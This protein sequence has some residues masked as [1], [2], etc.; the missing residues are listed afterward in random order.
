M[1]GMI[2]SV[3]N[4]LLASG[5][6]LLFAIQDGQNPK[7]SL[8]GIEAATAPKTAKPLAFQAV[9][10]APSAAPTPE[11]VLT[12]VLLD[13]QSA[14]VQISVGL[15]IEGS[16]S[17][18]PTLHLSQA[19]DQ[20]ELTQNDIAAPISAFGFAANSRVQSATLDDAKANFRTDSHFALDR[21][22]AETESIIKAVIEEIR[23]LDGAKVVAAIDKLGENVQFVADAG[24]WVRKGIETLKSALDALV[25]LLGPK[26]LAAIKD[27][28]SELW[29]KFEKGEYTRDILTRIYGVQTTEDRIEATLAR[30]NLSPESLDHAGNALRPLT[31][32]FAANIKLIRGILAAVALI[33]GALAF[34]HVAL[35][36]LP[37]AAAG[38]Y[39]TLI[40]AAVIVGMSYSGAGRILPGIPDVREIAEHIQA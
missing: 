2:S 39:A 12:R 17:P 10:N 35:P 25:Q 14:N 3:S 38:A 5:R 30:P 33:V 20:I 27:K 23:K 36:W 29:S 9:G 24:H 28:V 32:S 31:E 18:D 13:L 6:K 8:E 21:L 22:V 19:L 26:A 16:T 7:S 15:A 40:G 1:T 11:D 37:L 34:L 4:Q